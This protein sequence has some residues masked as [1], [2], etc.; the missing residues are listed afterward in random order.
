MESGRPADLHMH[1]FYSDGNL[2]PGELVLRASEAGLGAMS[3]TDHD[4]IDGQREAFDAGRESGIEVIS[5]I[6]FSVEEEGIEIHILGYLFDTENPAMVEASAML[7]KARVDRAGKIVEKIG[8]SGIS[9]GIGEVLDFAGRGTVGRLHVAR[10]LLDGGYVSDIQEAFNRFIGQ[11][12]PA[13]VA[14]KILP[15]A[16]VISIIREAGGVAVWAHPGKNIGKKEIL[17]RMIAAGIGGLEA[18]HPNHTP[19]M[20]AGILSQALRHGL[21]STGGSDYHFPEA[22]KAQIGRFYTPPE[23]FER[24][25][26]RSG[27]HLT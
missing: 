19:A 23:S 17:G 1:S 16:E 13:Y 24:L 25:K 26:A 14:K 8:E 5:G 2:S 3:I 9:I 20:T 18:W 7:E 22:M 15:M 4:T 21:V 11:G 6:E 10:L 27:R 12:C